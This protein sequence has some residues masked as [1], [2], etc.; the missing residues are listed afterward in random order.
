LTRC[1]G[2]GKSPRPAANARAFWRS[3]AG[4]RELPAAVF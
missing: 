3:V 4:E 1:P 2:R